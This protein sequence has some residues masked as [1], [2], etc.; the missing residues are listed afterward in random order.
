MKYQWSELPQETQLAA[1]QQATQINTTYLKHRD[2]DLPAPMVQ[3]TQWM[4]ELRLQIA[5]ILRFTSLS[6]A[7]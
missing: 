2:A 3:L 6:P 7:N 4:E 1:E 5:K